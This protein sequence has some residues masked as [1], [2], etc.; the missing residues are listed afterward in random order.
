MYTIFSNSSEIAKKNLTLT[1]GG[2]LLQKENNPVYLGV[3][4]DRQLN[5]NTH[6]QKM[7]E[8]SSRRLKI[9]KRL[10][11]TQWGANK[12]TLRQL[13]IGYVRSTMEYNLALQSIASK[14][15]QA[16]FDRVES[17][18][19][20]FIAGAMR[21]APTAACHIH[22]NIQPIGLRREAAVLEMTERYRRQEKHLP[23]AKIVNEWKENTRIQK[24]SILKVEKKLQEKHHLPE[25]RKTEH[26]IE[27]NRQPGQASRTP[28]I[29]LELKSKM[30]KQSSDV[31][32]MQKTGLQT[33]Q[34]YPD[35]CIHVYTDGSAFKGTVNAGYGVRIEYP[36]KSLEEISNPCGAHCSNFEAE[37]IAINTAIKTIKEKFTENPNL[38][39]KIVI[40]SD[41]KSV[42]QALNS[43]RYSSNVI[44]ELSTSM[45][46]FMNEFK[47]EITLQWIPSHC[48]ING[49]ERADALAKKGASKEQP[50][51]ETSLTT[52]KEIIK[53]NS[54]IEWMNNWALGNTGRAMFNY[55]TA[56]PKTDNLDNLGRRDQSIIFRLRSEH[57]ALN[58]HLNR[59]NPMHEPVCPLCPCPH[60]TVRHFLFECPQ[61]CQ[62]RK[63]FLPPCPNIG[64]TLYGDTDQLK[65][66][67]QYFTLANRQR[68]N[69]QDQAGSRR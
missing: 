46:L 48:E 65:K 45:D 35:N 9:I 20:H 67:A 36:D 22:T 3:T 26:F 47:Q 34:S 54:K 41:A 63:T 57:V 30:S 11:S 1:I 64:N 25:H 4:L 14:T 56:P 33:I 60:E 12:K 27:K 2:E 15:T 43:E 24:K 18:A 38:Q 39:T 49:N 61:L 40:F 23:N 66:T 10:A 53:S 29:H 17:S 42:L 28:N 59:L 5:L 58:M 32:D 68:T 7:K 51:N 62:L 55:M 37:A 69:V 31:L 52:C 8:K 44:Q 16:T 6:M 19:V 50:E 21:S 13:Y